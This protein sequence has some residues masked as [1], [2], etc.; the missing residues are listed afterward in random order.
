MTFTDHVRSRFG[1]IGD[2]GLANRD[3]LFA[4]A[5][6]M[7]LAVL[8]LPVPSWFL[9]LGLALSFSV[10]VLVLMVSLWIPRPLDFSSFPTVLLVVTMM[11][12]ALN[13]ASTRLILSE[14][15]NG[16]GAAGHVIQ[17]FSQS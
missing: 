16:H 11:R 5:I 9:D 15:H 12:L 2:I 14:G 3:V 7:V 10:A 13:I 17:G 8:F 4:V 1:L 6:L